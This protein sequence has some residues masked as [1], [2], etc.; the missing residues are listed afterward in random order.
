MTKWGSGSWASW[1]RCVLVLV[2]STLLLGCAKDTPSQHDALGVAEEA[3]TAAI[4]SVAVTPPAATV[5]L[6]ATQKLTA[7]ATLADGKTKT[8]TTGVTWTSS[9]PA[10]ASV[11]TTGIVKGLA[12]GDSVITVRETATGK[13]ASANISVPPAVLT[14]VSV[15]PAN[16]KLALHA[17]QAFTATG[18]FDDKSKAALVGADVVQWDSSNPGVASITSAG[19][20]TAQTPGNTLITATHLATGIQGSVTL[21]VNPPTLTSLALTPRP[22]ALPIGTSQPLLATGVYSDASKQDLTAQVSFSSSAPAI[23]SVDATGLVRGL[24]VGT[25]LISGTFG[26][27]TGTASV[28]VKPVTLTSIVAQGNPMVPNGTRWMSSA[29]GYYNDGSTRSITNDVTWTSSAPTVVS[30]SNVLGGASPKGQIQ[31]L[32]LGTA[33]ITATDPVTKVKGSFNVTVTAAELTSMVVS[34][35][36][37]TQQIGLPAKFTAE[38][39]FSDGTHRDVTDEAVWSIRLQQ[40]GSV[41][42]P[43]S[44]SNDG[45]SSGEAVGFVPGSF[46]VSAQIRSRGLVSA[47]AK[48]DVT[49]SPLLSSTASPMF[50]YVGLGTQQEFHVTAEFA[51]RST[52]DYTRFMTWS[53]ADEAVGTISNAAGSEGVFTAGV[54]GAT[55]ITAQFP[56]AVN[57]IIFNVVVV[58]KV[59]TSLT[60]T[61]DTQSIAK[62]LRGRA[63]VTAT[64]SNGTQTDSHTDRDLAWSLNWSMANPAILRLA[65]ARAA[66]GASSWEDL[67]SLQQ[68][69][70]T[71]TALDPLTGLSASADVT[72]TDAIVAGYQMQPYGEVLQIGETWSLDGF[73]VMTDATQRPVNALFSSSDANVGLVSKTSFVWGDSYRVTGVGAG[74]FTLTAFWPNGDQTSVAVVVGACAP[75]PAGLLSFWNA[76]SGNASDKL[77]QRT[78][79]GYGATSYP[80]GHFGRTFSFDTDGGYVQAPAAGLPLGGADRTIEAWVRRDSGNQGGE[81]FFVGYGAM[82]TYYGGFALGTLPDGTVFVSTW[83]PAVLGPVLGSQWTHLAVTT[84]GSVVALYVNGVKVGESLLNM[85]TGLGDLFIGG[86]PNDP[87][88]KLNGAVDEVGVYDRALSDAEIAAIAGAEGGR[89]H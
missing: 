26:G 63:Y 51:N 10:I 47:S 35:S 9:Q 12:P 38:G 14:T 81:S 28:T 50:A 61:P 88:R 57:A 82:G 45:A 62:G 86:R 58:D 56:R 17:M 2:A 20:A 25:A 21:T 77:Q 8:L 16:K 5:R 55:T 52:L 33:I 7:V 75:A 65:N 29:I 72:V 49:D 74:P 40:N 27:K 31:G 54:N 66:W 22:V 3:L 23:A 89:C 84:T 6:K 13:E 68:G 41:S 85:N 71:V 48:L 46:A 73:A 78:G 79:V 70:T 24:T 44:V 67:W 19:A 32:K 36:A 11:G 15:A 60:L 69:Q 53:V 83:G 1:A 59:I 30:V 39:T 37:A 43:G 76:D 80:F 42:N 4:V 87:Y 64:Y 18:I 34:P